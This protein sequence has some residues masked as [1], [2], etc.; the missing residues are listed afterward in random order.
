MSDSSSSALIT[1][2]LKHVRETARIRDVYEDI[3]KSVCVNL[4]LFLIDA[5]HVS[6]PVARPCLLR[7]HRGYSCG[8]VTNLSRLIIYTNSP[9]LMFT[10]SL[11]ALPLFLSFSLSPSHGSLISFSVSYGVFALFRLKTPS[12]QWYECVYCN[13]NFASRSFY[14]GVACAFIIY[15]LLIRS[16]VPRDVIDLTNVSLSFIVTCT[17]RSS[18]NSSFS[19]R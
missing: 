2:E 6:V 8:N 3:R 18:L 9:E 13:I 5:L 11:R 17:T 7:P 16:L 14:I 15:N 19:F 12:S 4:A 1:W 10:S